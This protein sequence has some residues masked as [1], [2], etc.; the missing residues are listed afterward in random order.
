[1]TG[2]GSTRENATSADGKRTV[3]VINARNLIVGTVV[4]PSRPLTAASE[5]VKQHR[6]W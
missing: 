2:A 3:R 6:S 1:M 5:H 4:P